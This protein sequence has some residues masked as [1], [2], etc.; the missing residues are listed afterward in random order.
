MVKN[1]RRNYFTYVILVLKDTCYFEKDWENALII[2]K[3]FF[4]FG[5]SGNVKIKV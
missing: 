4:S 3:L 5:R 1:D 2:V